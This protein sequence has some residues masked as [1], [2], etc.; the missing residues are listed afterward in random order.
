MTHAVRYSEALTIQVQ[1]GFR[2]LI[3]KAALSAGTKPTEWHRQAL[4][5]AL[6]AAGIDPAPR[7]AATAGALYDSRNEAGELQHRFAWVE[8][9]EIKAIG[10]GA[11]KPGDGWLPVVHVD[12][13]PF[14]AALHWRLTPVY[15]IDANRVVCTYHVVAKSL[16]AI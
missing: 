3:D 11:E 9:G 10:Y 4:A 6:R 5:A 13:E 2:S 7:P 8:A 15:S 12:S 14:D 1:P 16:E